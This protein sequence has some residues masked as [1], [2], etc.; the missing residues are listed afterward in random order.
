MHD[1]FILRG[2]R[3]YRIGNVIPRK[4]CESQLVLVAISYIIYLGRAIRSDF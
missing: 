1:G 4:P 2:A 3:S